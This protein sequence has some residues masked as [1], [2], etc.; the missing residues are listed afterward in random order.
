[1]TI[2]FKTNQ[3]QTQQIIASGSAVNGGPHKIVV[4]GSD[5]TDG[6]N[7]GIISNSELSTNAGRP[8][9]F[10]YISGSIGGQHSSDP[11]VT[12]F[13]GDTVV[14]GNLTA[15]SLSGSLT[16]L[17]DGT[18]YLLAGAN[19]TLDI[20]SNG[21]I[22]IESSG[23]GGGTPDY[24]WSVS[25][26]PIS[27]SLNV[28]ETQI[29]YSNAANVILTS[30]SQI[31]G[32][33][34]PDSSS[35]VILGGEA[36]VIS[37]SVNAAIINS[38]SGT[39]SSSNN[40]NIFGSDQAL[41][42]ASDAANVFGGTQ[43]TLKG[44]KHS[45]IISSNKCLVSSSLDYG[46]ARNNI[47]ASVD[48]G[49]TTSWASNIFGA[50][51]S[52]IGQDASADKYLG[53]ALLLG[54]DKNILNGAGFY[55]TIVNSY[56]CSVD[57]GLGATYTAPTG[58]YSSQ[59]ATI[60]SFEG[61]S[62]S[63]VILGGYDN[64]INGSSYANIA[65]GRYNHMSASHWSVLAGGERN[66]ISESNWGSII[67]GTRCTIDDSAYNG[68]F[69]AVRSEIGNGSLQTVILGGITSNINN[70]D[71]CGV[72]GGENN[73]L[74]SSLNSVIIGG[75]N[76]YINRIDYSTIIASIDSTINC[77]IPT[78]GGSSNFI[79][80]SLDGLIEAL[81]PD[82]EGPPRSSLQ[83]ALL[84]G[85]SNTI[86]AAVQSGVFCGR[87]ST[88]DYSDKSVIL[89]GY[90]N[91]I[92][93]TGQSAILGGYS[94][95]ITGSVDEGLHQNSIIA[96]GL[97]NSVVLSHVTSIISSE[98]NQVLGS[99]ITGLYTCLSSSI[100]SSMT[101]VI[102][103]GDNSNITDAT[104][105]VIFGTG[106][107]I[108]S[109]NDSMAFGG[110][111]SLPVH[112][113]FTDKNVV[114]GGDGYL[115][116]ASA[117]SHFPRGLSGSLTTLTDGSPYLLA[118]TNITLSTGSA[119]EV[120]IAATGDAGANKPTRLNVGSYATSTA[121]IGSP[122]V[123]GAGYFVPD[124]HLS[125]TCKLISI[126]AT[127]DAVVNAAT[128]KLFNVTSGSFVEIGGSGIE[129]LELSEADATQIESVDLFTATNFGSTDSIY[130][131]QVYGTGSSPT[132]I[133]YSSEL[134]CE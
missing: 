32:D 75:D 123:V 21:A 48:C 69:S 125:V 73:R 109:S 24:P 19:I 34:I 61:S 1:M 72:L 100:T 30:G 66:H 126:L 15:N 64:H 20:E 76:N 119:G 79:G 3:L 36:N 58:I 86:T 40:S 77:P 116:V 38:I 74:T 31:P 78:S 41:I 107:T 11:S 6:T 127:T 27:V 94:N 101:S 124:Q 83:S 5:D 88:V 52:Q 111:L 82:G 46:E 133:H 7:R 95:L 63:T 62:K 67:G 55:P 28:P 45:A 115:F 117:S 23:G 105:S 4:I 96:G 114:L 59:L 122:Q 42:T 97:N 2:D 120:T 131:V 129:F 35:S 43:N 29:L 128:V 106:N 91:D 102:L 81:L 54:G 90:V 132:T 56:N 103:G 112:S 26:T 47:F 93:S 57:L 121:E 25:T 85:R 12:V 39:I 108:S 51:R 80:A 70:G 68:I 130:Q 10:L 87:A 99:N 84:G 53:G 13:G 33:I 98:N 44:A 113:G 65:G 134:V 89:G 110:N 50:A 37:S 118:G 92:E 16:T 71:H 14:S 18:P 49:I 17:S 104:G 9:V 22:T 8:D 60:Q